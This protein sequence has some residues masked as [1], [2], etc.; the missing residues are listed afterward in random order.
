MAGLGTI[1]RNASKF[2]L[3]GRHARA[4]S[5]AHFDLGRSRC[6]DRVDAGSRDRA[7]GAAVSRR[8]IAA[9]ILF[10]WDFFPQHYREIGRIPAALAPI[11]KAWEQ[12]LLRQFTA[13]VCSL[14]GNADYL[15]RH[16]RLDPAQRVLV[17]P[18]WCDASPRPP[19]DRAAVRAEFG[20]PTDR[21]IAV[22]GGQL[23]EGRGFE[24]MLGAAEAAR[25]AA[26]AMLFLFIGEGRLAPVIAAQ[27]S[28][29]GTVRLLPRVSREDY[30]RLV[31][32]CDV[33][34]VATVPGVTSYSIPSKTLDYLRAGI[35]VI[36]AV[37]HG[38]DY[39]A[40]LS[41][42]Q[43]GQVVPFGEPAQFF[44]EAERL[45][46]DPAAREAARAG[47]P[48]CLDAIF[49]VRHAVR[50]LLD[51]VDGTAPPPLEKDLT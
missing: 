33:G 25:Q 42:N 28:A 43:V 37:E 40:L 29:A 50:T 48:R 1:V 36:A 22:F 11:A 6:G 34:M 17:T 32:A 12:S 44:R 35:P 30:L 47:A 21:P 15:R 19:I 46:T 27:S 16:F 38:N 18:V 9:R 14:P 41:D 4:V 51:A 5:R 7:P 24:Q 31:A 3:S 26:S 39:A 13:I 20:L 2:V 10:I 23:V 45:A 8:G 49:D